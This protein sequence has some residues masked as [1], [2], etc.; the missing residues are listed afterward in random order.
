MN[1]LLKLLVWLVVCPLVAGTGASMQKESTMIARGTFEVKTTPQAKDET[2]GPFDRFFL[3]KQFHGDLDG[4]SKGQMLATRGV[5]TGSG[6]YVALESVTA[7]L[8]GRSGSFVLQHFGT[9]N[10]GAYDLKVVVVPNSG[11]G[12][13]QGITGKMNIIIEGKKH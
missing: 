3:D 12:E 13:F 4:N 10:S 1:R 5:E 11:T 8:N 7:K 9:M 2:G 6:G